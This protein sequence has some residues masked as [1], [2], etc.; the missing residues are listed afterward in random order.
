MNQ[1]GRDIKFAWQ[2][3]LNEKL[4]QIRLYE[5]RAIYSKGYRTLRR[6]PYEKRK[7][8]LVRTKIKKQTPTKRRQVSGRD[9][10]TQR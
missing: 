9:T 1:T 3:P 7:I 2:N 8:I 5:K 10:Y 6:Q 4:L